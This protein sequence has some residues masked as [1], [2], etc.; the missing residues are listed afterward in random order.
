M[1]RL[2]RDRESS[3]IRESSMLWWTQLTRVAAFNPQS[4][5]SSS[6]GISNGDRPLV[7]DLVCHGSLLFRPHT[8]SIIS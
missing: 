1:G 3:Y 5:S 2:L 8:H 7:K 6:S 4:I